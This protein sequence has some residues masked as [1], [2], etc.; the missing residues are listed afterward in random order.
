[1][2]GQRVLVVGMGKSGLAVLEVLGKKGAVLSACDIKPSS[3]FEASMLDS[4]RFKGIGVYT[5]QYPQVNRENFDLL[6]ASPG[7]S[8]DIKPFQEARVAGIPIIGELELAYQ[9]KAGQVQMAAITGTNGKTTTTALLQHILASDGRP[10]FSGGNIGTP[11]T[12]LVDM[13]QE[14]ILV[15][16]ASSFQMES[17]DTF[18]P[19]IC[20]LLN[21]TPDHL[22]R[23][24]TMKAYIQAKARIFENQGPDEWAVF[25]YEDA[26]LR[27]L[28]EK[29][30]AQ[31]LFFSAERVLEQ[32]AFIERDMIY[33]IDKG[34]KKEICPV[35][36]LTLRGRH[37]LENI[38]CAAAMAFLAGVQPEQIRLGL[39]TFSGVRHRME[40][41]AVKEGVL[42]INDSKA[43]NPDSVIK[44]LDAFNRPLILIAGGRNKGSDF[45]TLARVIKEKV[46]DLIILGEAR[47]ELKRA[48]MAVG[49]PN[50]YEVEDL[51]GAVAV[52]QEHA[53]EGD[54][55]L[56]S[57][58]CASW[59]MFENYEQ[60]GD[61]FCELV[62]S[63]TGADRQQERG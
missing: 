2:A 10:A 5:G 11:L 35:Q 33:I 7:I 16:E 38:L 46:K 49:F 27:K 21:I 31:V 37:N 17:I 45:S 30:P 44:A 61:I 13:L 8:L 42:Y 62:E 47:E 26:R 57:P 48:V 29:C 51:R 56:L 1:M 24:G 15:V 63:L 54:V 58:A 6:V 60:R 4:L 34:D 40:E 12:L 28:V 19:S 9:L 50:I 22:D 23:H 43:T 39:G 32:G 52:A 18:R 36:E 14:G 41:V 59:D 55:V 53:T 20:G 25:N 3:S